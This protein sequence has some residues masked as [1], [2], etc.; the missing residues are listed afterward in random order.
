MH[1]LVH[2]NRLLLAI[3]LL[4]VLILK[5]LPVHAQ[6]TPAAVIADLQQQI[7]KAPDDTNKINLLLKLSR[8]YSINMD[9]NERALTIANQAADLS[10]EL[11]SKRHIRI[12]VLL[13]GHLQLREGEI[14]EALATYEPLF[15]E[16]RKSGDQQEE[17]RLYF[18]FGKQI[19]TSTEKNIP[20]K[21]EYFEKS[22]ALYLKIKRP[23]L[24]KEV[25]NYIGRVYMD[26]GKI[27]LAEKLYQQQLEDAIKRGEKK[28]QLIYLGLSEVAE[29]K[30]DYGKQ[31]YYDLELLKIA[32]EPPVTPSKLN[33]KNFILSQLAEVY[34]TMK[35][36]QEMLAVVADGIKLSKE[37]E[38]LDMYYFFCTQQSK[39]LTALNK[40]DEAVATATK[41][42]RDNPPTND[43]QRRLIYGVI[44]KAYL[45][46]GRP[47]KATPY[48]LEMDRD[49]Q[50]F[51][52]AS[53]FSSIVNSM[54]ASHYNQMAYFYYT[55]GKYDKAL[56]FVS[57]F[58]QMPQHQLLIANR[59]YNTGLQIKIDSA[60]GDYESAFRHLTAY[61]NMSDSIN[62][63]KNNQAMADLMIKY[64]TE[65]KDK[66]LLQQQQ[67]IVLLQKQQQ[68]KEGQLAQAGLQLQLEQQMRETEQQINT[69]HNEKREKEFKYAAERQDNR[70]SFLN[71]QSQIQAATL[72]NEKLLRNASLLGLLLTSI[73]LG[74][75]Y[76]SYRV[77]KKKNRQL[78]LQKSEIDLKNQRL[79]RLVAEK[80][81]LLKELHHRVKNNLQ[82]VISLLNIQS[83]YLEDKAAMLAIRDTQQRVHSMALIHKKLYLS[84]QVDLI[85]MPD[86]INELVNDLKESFG[87]GQKI[88][89]ET[90]VDDIVM[91]TTQVVPLG[92]I[93]NEAVTNCVKYA[94]P[95]NQSGTVQIQMLKT[96]TDTL[97]V[98]IADNG[99]GLPATMS[100]SYENSLG[101]SIIQGL[102]GDLDGTCH[103]ETAA[104]TII[105]IDFPENKDNKKSGLHR[106]D[107]QT[108]NI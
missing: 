96:G 107:L 4:S 78:T 7:S 56:V 99:V 49:A 21:L 36:Y 101:M 46:M 58:N 5:A 6:Q 18:D 2:I 94:F 77:N 13:K 64:E 40:Y 63:N 62:N 43:Y 11:A 44:G 65:K 100:T 17:A 23:D 108:N 79:S 30:A 82:I 72:A 59:V 27:D 89:F 66:A 12:A 20:I 37:I 92:L 52:S 71:Q 35:K 81:W 10:G 61:H 22:S 34:Y 105:S 25:R 103:I 38:D 83:Y 85:Y 15:A 8:Y 39:G 14:R 76:N 57:K 67:N 97:R 102:S 98:T 53:R 86:Y 48:Y 68:I 80:E 1:F 55:V 26:Q 91:D 90:Q 51:E 84:D 50:D 60:R 42:I 19:S 106:P 87:V 45:E 69:Y 33:W 3:L 73:I 31:L 29:A 93:I 75:L 16:V 41:A 95:G 74:L 54:R 88:R 104:G 32:N 9:D 70:I 47:E 28:F 24:D